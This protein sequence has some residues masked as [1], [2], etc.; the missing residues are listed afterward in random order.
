MSTVQDP[1]LYNRLNEPCSPEEAAKRAEE[2]ATGLRELR[3]RCKVPEVVYV[4]SIATPDGNYATEGYAGSSVNA[5]ILVASLYGA[6]RRRMATMLDAFA[7]IGGDD[8]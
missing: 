1:D 5:P 4:L 6:Y 8:E 7:G 2:F 3:E